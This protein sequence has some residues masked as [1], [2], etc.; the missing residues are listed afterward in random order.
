VPGSFCHLLAV[1]HA[2]PRP[3]SGAADVDMLPL[4]AMELQAEAERRKRASILESEGARQARINV[5][6]GDKQQVGPFAAVWWQ[7]A[8][9]HFLTIPY[10]L[11]PWKLLGHNHRW[12]GTDRAP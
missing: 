6:E 9:V 1:K 10:R 2:C 11:C 3:W 5:A 4:Q 7:S 12:G 8:P